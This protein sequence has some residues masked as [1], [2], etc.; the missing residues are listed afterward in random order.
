MLVIKLEERELFNP[1]SS[2]FVAFKSRTVR[3]EHSLISISKW[4][5]IWEKPF[6][7]KP[8]MSPH[9]NEQLKSYIQCMIIGDVPHNVVDV[10]WTNHGNNIQ[11]YIES[12]STATVVNKNKGGKKGGQ[13]VTSELIYYWMIEFNIPFETERWHLNRLLTLIDVCNASRMKQNKPS[14]KDLMAQRRALNSQRRQAL[15]SSG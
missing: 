11:A 4:E 12:S 2:E 13:F 6:I 14:R 9:T 5:A 7:L 3:L 8:D 15:G 1:A 10:L